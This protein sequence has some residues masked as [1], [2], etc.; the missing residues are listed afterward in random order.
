M[1]NSIRF[2]PLASLRHKGEA[3]NRKPTREGQGNF[4]DPCCG[5]T[6]SVAAGVDGMLGDGTAG[7]SDLLICRRK[8]LAVVEVR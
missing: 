5:K 4:G 2:Y 3:Q 6:V 7:S 1:M 8:W